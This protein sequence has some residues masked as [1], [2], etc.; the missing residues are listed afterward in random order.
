M[1]LTSNFAALAARFSSAVF[2]RSSHRRIFVSRPCTSPRRL[3]R[4]ARRLRGLELHH[5]GAENF[6]VSFSSNHFTPSTAPQSANASERD[7]SSMLHARLPMYTFVL[8]VGNVPGAGARGS[9]RRRRLAR[10]RPRT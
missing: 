4:P 3:D 8:L 5:P 10:R 7:A 1:G 9:T 6:F 2:P